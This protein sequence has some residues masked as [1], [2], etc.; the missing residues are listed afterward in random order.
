MLSHLKGN[1]ETRAEKYVVMDIGGVGFKVFVSPTTLEQLPPA[2]QRVALHTHLYVR[3]EALEM[4]GFL[5][6]PELIFFE[7]L[8]SVSGVGPRVALGVLSV[9]PVNA[10]AAAIAKG[11]AELLTKVSGVGN[12][13]AQKIILELKDKIT[14][15]GFGADETEFQDHEVIDALV[16]LGYSQAQARSA[17]RNLPKETKGVEKRIKEALKIL[18]R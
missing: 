18:G 7:T 14:K 16:S 13:V 12:K 15:L 1:L 11:Q 3:Q 5:T 6:R 4:Y 9:A 8:L 10:I 17:I 2:G